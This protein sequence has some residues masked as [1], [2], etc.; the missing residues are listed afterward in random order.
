LE[1][2]ATGEEQTFRGLGNWTHGT[3]LSQSRGVWGG[4]PGRE[5]KPIE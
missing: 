2:E 1:K 5:R 4:D 3:G